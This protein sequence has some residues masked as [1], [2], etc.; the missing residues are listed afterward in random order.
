MKHEP[1]PGEWL[2]PEDFDSVV[3][4]T[5]LVVIDLIVQSPEGRILVGRRSNEPAK[6]SFF[7]PGG[8]I[9]KNETLA[10]AFRRISSAELGVEK[11]IVDARFLGVYEHFY[12]TNNHEL[13][14]FGTH[15]VVLAYRLAAAVEELRLPKDQH[16]EFAWLTEAELLRRAD[17]HENTKAY[18]ISRNATG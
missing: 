5:P 15:Y 6:G 11:R 7:V 18:F 1:K 8:R 17:V 12:A 3:R 9:S 16:G 14:G 2:A 13:A 4:M 10:A